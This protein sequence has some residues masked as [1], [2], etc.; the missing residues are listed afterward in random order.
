MTWKANFVH[1]TRFEAAVMIIWPAYERPEGGGDSDAVS[2]S[3]D[4][5]IQVERS[6]ALLEA[7]HF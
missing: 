6:L 4:N 7:P 3:I 1:S 5:F 2:E